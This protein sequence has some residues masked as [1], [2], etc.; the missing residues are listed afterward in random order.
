M[1][2]WGT[3]VTLR[4]G[5]VTSVAVVGLGSIT[6]LAML[7]GLPLHGSFSVSD[8]SV[9]G[10]TLGRVEVSAPVDDQELRYLTTDSADGFAHLPGVSG[11]A[12][13]YNVS[14]PWAERA[15][16]LAGTTWSPIDKVR[17]VAGRG[18][19]RPGEIVLPE[20]VEGVSTTETLGSSITID[21]V[22][23]VSEGQGR[24]TP[25]RFRVVGISSLEHAP[26]RPDTAY[27]SGVDALRLAAAR[28]GMA[29]ADFERRRGA[30]S[31]ILVSA[32]TDAAREIANHLRAEHF[33]A[34]AT[35]D[36]VAELG[37]TPGLARIVGWAFA[38]LAS[39]GVAAIAAMRAR[40]AGGPRGGSPG[41]SEIP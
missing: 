11:V 26:D 20:R 13:T 22:W 2:A 31:I 18:A 39:L 29:P 35:V 12:V 6:T 3:A 15:A 21:A 27:L 24:A 36:W 38:A 23:R 33:D 5:V 25:E 34:R 19:A 10:A 28:E 40:T 14:L 4:R 16:N 7:S 41:S 30:D 37:G 1:R 17:L 9:A 32:S 8:D